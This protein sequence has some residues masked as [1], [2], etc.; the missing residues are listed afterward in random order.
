MKNFSKGKLA[1]EEI[2]GFALIV[3]IVFIILLVFLSFYLRGSNKI[4]IQSYE[5][6]SFIQAVLQY[7]SKCER[8]GDFLAVQDL[9]F[10]HDEEC[11]NEEQGVEVLNETLLG[12]MDESWQI[13]EDTPVKGYELNINEEDV[14]ILNLNKGN[15]TQNYRGGFQDFSKRGRDYNIQLKIY[16]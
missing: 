5:A 2:V 13:G 16:Y 6:D 7:T 8:G 14:A 15:V 3:I 9:I 10:E 4:E 12:I 1:Q 11:L